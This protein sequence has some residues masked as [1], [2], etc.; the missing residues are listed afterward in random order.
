M[1]VGHYFAYGSNMNP[2]RVRERG[3]RTVGCRGAVL[4]DVRLVFDKVSRQ[5]P[6]EAH[7]NI[8]YA[9]GSRVEGVLYELAIPEE[10]LK[11]DRFERAPVNYGR[12]VVIV[13]AGGGGRISTWTYFANA[14]VRRA[15]LRP[16][17]SYLNHL[18]AGV[19]Y[20]SSGYHGE[21][22]RTACRDE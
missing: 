12:D 20:L 9:P 19:D 4:D 10:I 22:A 21:L 3:L 15:G 11:M 17:R 1:K 13:T 18:L 8:V 14:S 6:E 7:A 5:H 2:T 16:S